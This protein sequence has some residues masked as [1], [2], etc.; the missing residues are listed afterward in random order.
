[1]ASL[2]VMRRSGGVHGQWVQVCRKASRD[3]HSDGAVAS[4]VPTDC[5]CSLPFAAGVVMMDRREAGIEPQV[6][7][8]D[9]NVDEGGKS[10][11]NA[12]R[13]ARAFF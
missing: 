8:D 3:N 7:V 10:N 11:R 4:A 9:E 1:M 12:Q 6:L 2:G 13:A 5:C